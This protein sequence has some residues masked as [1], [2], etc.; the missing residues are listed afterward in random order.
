MRIPDA[1]EAAQLCLTV[2]RAV[3]HAHDHKIVHRDLKPGNIVMDDQGQP[4][5]TDFGLAKRE[6]ADVTIAVSGQILGTPAYM[7]PEQVENAHLADHRAD[8]YS[9]GVMLY[10]LLCHQRP[11]AGGKSTLLSQILH[12]EPKPPRAIN[13][14]IPRNLETICLK[15]LA[16]DPAERYQ[17]AAELADDLERFLKHEPIQGRRVPWLRRTWRWARRR[18]AT[19][20]AALLVALVLILAGALWWRP[21]DTGPVPS[22]LARLVKVS[23]RPSKAQI[24]LVPLHPTTRMPQPELG[25]DA[26]QSPA[27]VSCEP[28]DYLVVAYQNDEVFHEVYRHVPAEHEKVG[29]QFDYNG[30]KLDGEL[31]VWPQIRLFGTSEV[32]RN[33]ARVTGGEFTMNTSD[34]AGPTHVTVPDFYLDVTEVTVGDLRRSALWL[35][36]VLASDSDLDDQWPVHGLRWGEAVQLA[37]QLGKRLQRE[38]AFMYVATSGGLNLTSSGWQVVDDRVPGPVTDPSFDRVAWDQLSKEV[39]GLRSNVLE[40]TSNAFVGPGRFGFYVRRGGFANRKAENNVSVKA[41]LSPP[42]YPHSEFTLAPKRGSAVRAAS[43]RRSR[44]RTSSS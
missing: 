27:T 43:T 42:R 33:M 38:E 21:S 37:E 32:I 34:F 25:F 10:E 41:N 28:G 6:G 12:D 30:F 17:T 15:T 23:T 8:I 1:R 4:H 5:I 24:H 36:A 22:T 7:A 39:I 16:K 2:T 13:R 14:K 31:V 18:P 26:G 11:F 40:F 44:C 20:V 19:V 35:P 29:G 3:Q 9:L